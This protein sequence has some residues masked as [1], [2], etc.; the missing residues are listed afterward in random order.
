M[1]HEYWVYLHYI[2]SSVEMKKARLGRWHNLA[3]IFQNIVTDKVEMKKARLGRWHTSDRFSII[4]SLHDV[5]MKK[6][7]L[8]RWHPF[9]S[10]AQTAAYTG[11]NEESPFRALTPQAD[12]YY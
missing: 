1:T 7:R 11:R 10:G 9:T 2:L 3:I 5:E 6:A 8:G 12:N 4:C